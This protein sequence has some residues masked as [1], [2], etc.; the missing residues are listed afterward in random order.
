[1]SVSKL[2]AANKMK[3]YSKGIARYRFG[4]D[5]EKI[6]KRAYEKK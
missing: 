3:S 2:L 6:R 1:M 5:G 4:N